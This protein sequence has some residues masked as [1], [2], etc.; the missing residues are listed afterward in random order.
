MISGQINAQEGQG[1]KVQ[2]IAV[3]V[4]DY[5][6]QPE[7][8]Y[9]SGF[10]TVTYVPDCEPL[11]PCPKI[12]KIQNFDKVIINNNGNCKYELSN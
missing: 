1:F 3:A 10:V 12:L 8:P 11:E 9:V 5:L 4:I 2:D 7:V 6:V